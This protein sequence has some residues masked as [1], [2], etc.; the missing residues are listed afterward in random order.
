MEKVTKGALA[1]C[2]LGCLGLITEERPEEVT[3][4]DGSKGI[5]YVAS[6]LQ[7]K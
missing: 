4:S 5:A 3:Y 7:I 1:F 6:T 2:S